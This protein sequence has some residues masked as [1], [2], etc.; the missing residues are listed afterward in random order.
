MGRDQL[1]FDGHARP[2]CSDDQV[3]AEPE[4]AWAAF[5]RAWRLR[6]LSFFKRDPQLRAECEEMAFDVLREAFVLVQ[7]ETRDESTAGVL[8]A[9]AREA[10]RDAKRR[11]RHEIPL[12][13]MDSLIDQQHDL[14]RTREEMWAWLEPL[15][16]VLPKR[17]RLALE[18]HLDG[19]SDADIARELRCRVASIRVLRKRAIRALQ[20]MAA[21]SPRLAGN[22]SALSRRCMPE[23]VNIV[24]EPV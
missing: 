6:L 8:W 17:Q 1:Q 15:V 7:T 22:G 5:V 12:A 10:A 14:T 3:S 11:V 19:A 18:R 16:D 2:K 23:P 9:L 21:H 4:A 20:R 13:R 24:G